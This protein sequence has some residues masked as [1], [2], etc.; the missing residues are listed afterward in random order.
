MGAVVLVSL[1]TAMLSVTLTAAAPP[2]PAATTTPLLPAAQA[3]L[4][5]QEYEEAREL[6][7]QAW[8]RGPR[9]AALALA[10]GQVYRH[11][12]DY[13]RA[14]GFL[15][16]ARRQEPDNPEVLFLL[17]DTLIALDR[18]G[19]AR[20]LLAGLAARGYRPGP[21]QYLLGL[22]AVKERRYAEAAGHFRQAARD[23]AL[24]QEAALQEAL[25]LAAGR[26]LRQAESRLQETAR[27]DPLTLSGAM[28]QSL[29]HAWEPRLPEA[30]RFRMHVAAGF[31]YDSNVT[32]QPGA[33]AAAQ[34]VSGQ[35]DVFYHHLATLEYNLL[36]SGPWSLWASY[37]FYQT[38]HRR[39]TRYD[40][41]SH[42][43]GLTPAYVWPMTRLWLPFYFSYVDIGSDKYSTAFQATPTLLHLLTPKVGL[44]AG[45]RLARLYYWFPVF[46]PQ[47]DRSGRQI[48]TSAGVYYFLADGQG[49]MLL[50]FSYDHVATA[51]DN[52]D[53]N[54]YR[55]TL[56]ARYP[57]TDRLALRGLAEI[58]WQPY[59][60]TWVG[61]NF[62]ASNPRR[63]DTIY[64]VGAEAS[65]RLWRGLEA[66]ASY[67]FIRDDSNIALYDYRRHLVGLQLGYRH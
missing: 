59:V 32:L 8:E 24:A 57:L 30:R 58:S 18:T 54:A 55:L 33:A 34:Q 26:R 51:G 39:L 13:P 61:D 7:L 11:L 49:F 67:Y 64:T 3:H 14:L 53:R 6:L 23:P 36:P 40:V 16:E 2:P 10:L 41:I 27:L 31:A 1:L 44:E 4:A 17:A 38:L 48:G 43:F 37:N 56:G 60:H 29:L 5:R 25:A 45:L 66:V 42:T 21:T 15:E 19:E 46:Q 50:R 22:A 47:D 28:A 52:W 12:L 63:R 20:P 9:T 65:Y 35:G 62:A